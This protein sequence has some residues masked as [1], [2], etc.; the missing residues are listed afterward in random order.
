MA[1][2]KYKCSIRCYFQHNSHYT[3]HLQMLTL[4]DIGKWIE[5]YRFTHPTLDSIIVKVYYDEE[6]KNETIE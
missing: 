4:D 2:K 6:N 3:H 5:A 1:I